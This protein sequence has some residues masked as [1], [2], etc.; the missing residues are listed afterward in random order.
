M[1]QE[2]GA[3]HEQQPSRLTPCYAGTASVAKSAL[4]TSTPC[5]KIEAPAQMTAKAKWSV[6]DS[7]E[8][9]EEHDLFYPHHNFHYETTFQGTK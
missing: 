4:S 7:P 3:E 9:S 6:A 8:T 2:K 5:K 1:A